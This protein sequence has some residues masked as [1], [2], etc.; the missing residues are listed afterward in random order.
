MSPQKSPLS[1]SV[2]MGTYQGE[3]YL[4]E[5]LDS[6]AQQTLLPMELVVTDDGST[7]GTIAILQD[8]EQRAP[9]PVR[10]FR[11]EVRL[12]YADN[13]LRAASL[14]RGDLIAF[15][16]QDDI[17]LAQKLS[18]CAA[19]FS[20]P[21]VSLVIHSAQTFSQPGVLGYHFPKFERTQ[22][23][24]WH[25]ANPFENV[26]G[27]AMVFR[28]NLLA[29][30]EASTRPVNLYSHDHWVWFLAATLGRI[31]KVS[32]VLSLYRQH[33]SNV[34]G[35]SQKSVADKLR[36]GREIPGYT[37]VAEAEF[38]CSRALLAALDHCPPDSKPSLRKMARA[39]AFRAQLHSLRARMYE[40]GAPFLTR[41]RIFVSISLRGGYFPD[42]SKMRLGPR[43]ALKDL[44]L[45]IFSL[46][47]LNVRAPG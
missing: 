10:I 44:V 9:F 25:R 5:Q 24:R 18:T 16:D 15:C 19:F 46:S 17:W 42:P 23:L 22:A 35:A 3:K 30:A 4:A 37:R 39:L 26:P 21:Q 32:Q 12:K 29:T 1:I 14:C 2:A 28:R 43:A 41:T 36:V 45:G 40:E 13:F 33:E 27:F 31:V 20:N 7:D 38:A 34:Y 6:I 8:F 47:R 11:N